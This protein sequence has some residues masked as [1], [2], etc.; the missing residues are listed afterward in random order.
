M[1]VKSCNSVLSLHVDP[2]SYDRL[3][4]HYEHLTNDQHDPLAGW[5]PT[6]LPAHGQRA[7][8]AGCGAVRHAVVIAVRAPVSATAWPPSGPGSI[9]SPPTGSSRPISST[10]HTAP[11]SAVQSSPSSLT[12]APAGGPHRL[13]LRDRGWCLRR[14]RRCC[15]WRTCCG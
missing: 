12:C 5:L 7:L 3:A 11:C 4:E 8:D 13:R 15:R 14:R 9:I 6:A 1:E 10:R 2:Q